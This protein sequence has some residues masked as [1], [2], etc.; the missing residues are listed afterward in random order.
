[1]KRRAEGQIVRRRKADVSLLQN[2]KDLLALLDRDAGQIIGG[3][4]N[5][6]APYLPADYES[7][8]DVYVLAGG[9][10]T[11]FTFDE[12]TNFYLAAQR[13][14]DDPAG[15]E[16]I[17]VHELFHVI[18]TA[19]TPLTQSRMEEISKVYPLESRALAHLFN[20]YREGGASWVANAD[21]YSGTG[22]TITF[23]KESQDKYTRQFQFRRLFVSFEAYL[24]QLFSDPEADANKIYSAGFMDDGPL[25]YVG[26]YMAREIEKEQGADAIRALLSQ[27]PTA[28]FQ[29]YQSLC[30][31]NKDL[32]CF[33][34]TTDS[35]IEHAA[36]LLR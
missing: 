10:A 31:A 1:M 20:G 30:H 6:L 29:Q 26:F 24:Y 27:A 3:V 33:S 19:L 35:I 25:Y 21:N 5:R 18:Q 8:I 12:G 16:L 14:G 17:I 9:Y 22:P 28:F 4:C 2:A 34:P 13:I 7:N 36:G 11:G 23:F 15:L 32:L